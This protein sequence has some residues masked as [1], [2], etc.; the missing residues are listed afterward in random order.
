M[1]IGEKRIETTRIRLVCYSAETF[2]EREIQS[3]VE[4]ANV[5]R[6]GVVWVHVTGVHDVERIDRRGDRFGLHPPVRE[7]IFN[8]E[9]RPRLE[10][11]GD[12]V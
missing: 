2:E 7:D 1:H 4:L 3:V 9:Q 10:D 12:Y 11:H 6:R 5:R 8:I